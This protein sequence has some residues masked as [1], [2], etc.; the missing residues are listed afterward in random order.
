MIKNVN[1]EIQLIDLMGLDVDSP[2]YVPA[3]ILKIFC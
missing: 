1:D 3:F 2:I